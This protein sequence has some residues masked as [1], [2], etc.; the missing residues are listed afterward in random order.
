M[1]RE[2]ALCG[3]RLR[4]IDAKMKPQA[5]SELVPVRT[6]TPFQTAQQ[7]NGRSSYCGASPVRRGVRAVR[8]VGSF[9]ERA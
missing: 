6:I 1:S 5:E 3:K 8:A 7:G 2:W 9:R 4:P